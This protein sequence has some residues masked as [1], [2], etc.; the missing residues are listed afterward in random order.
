MRN[1]PTFAT[2]RAFPWRGF[3]LSASII[4]M[5]GGGIVAVSTPDFAWVFA[6]GLFLFLLAGAHMEGD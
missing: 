2:P 3:A 1:R 4:C 6:V 5:I